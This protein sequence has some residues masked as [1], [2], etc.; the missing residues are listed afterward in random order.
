MLNENYIERQNQGNNIVF[1]KGI[2][3]IAIDRF[4]F[5]INKYKTQILS[6]HEFNKISFNSV[7]DL[8]NI[9]SKKVKICVVQITEDQKIVLYPNVIWE[10]TVYIE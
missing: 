2:E 9:S 8:N 7:T 4:I 10:R 1:L 3:T 5:D 6:Q